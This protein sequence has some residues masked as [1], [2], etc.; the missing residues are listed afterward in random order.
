[1]R[2]GWALAAVSVLALAL[3]TITVRRPS[4]ESPSPEG[5]SPEVR[6]PDPA[7]CPVD[8]KKANLDFTLEDIGGRNVRLTDY[9]GK[10][11]LLDFWATWCGPC[12]I[13][14]PGFVDLYSRYKSQGLEVVGVVVLDRFEKAGPFA[15]Q[16]RMNYPIV[17]GVD[18][19]DLEDAFGP[20][21][22]LPTTLLIGRDGR[23]C[24]RHIGLPPHESSGDDVGKAV[25]DVFE[26]EIKALL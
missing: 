24:S 11:L 5:P 13:E 12:K 7:V 22:G 3:V 17:D 15:Q 21:P 25:R 19:V 14:I 1:V 16:F 4:P 6:A 2:K 18:R 20:I 23:I 10:V 8:A 9:R 26:A